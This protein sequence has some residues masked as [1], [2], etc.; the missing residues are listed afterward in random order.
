[1]LTNRDFYHYPLAIQAVPGTELDLRIQYRADVF[2]EAAI[3]ALAGIGD[4]RHH[5]PLELVGQRGDGG[6]V[7]H[8]CAVLDAQVQFCAG[9]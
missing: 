8:V 1:D 2:D 7:E 3:A 5:H 6:L 9:H 4:H